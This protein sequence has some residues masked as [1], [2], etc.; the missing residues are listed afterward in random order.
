MPSS[1]KMH[2]SNGTPYITPFNRQPSNPANRSSVPVFV[3]SSAPVTVPAPSSVK[4][5]SAM[6]ASMIGRIHNIKSGCGS[7]GRH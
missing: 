5:P 4:A 1:I 3:P 6:N 7:C 2:L